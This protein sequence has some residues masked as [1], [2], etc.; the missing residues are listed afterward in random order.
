MGVP[1][2]L[3]STKL[4]ELILRL[5]GVTVFVEGNIIDLGVTQL[6]VVDACSGLRYILP[7]FALGVVFVNFY[8]KTRWKQIVVSISTLPIAI[9]VNALRIGIT[10]FLAQ[11]FGTEI[12]DGF[13]HGF[14]GWLIFILALLLVL[15]LFYILRGFSPKSH[16]ANTPNSSRESRPLQSKSGKNTFA[17]V[18]VSSILLLLFGIWS[19]TTAANPPLRIKGGLSYFPLTINGWHGRPENIDSRIISLSGAEDAFNGTY[20][21]AFGEIIS[22]YIGY[23]ASP[24][25]ESENFFH[26][27]NICLPSLGWN[28]LAISNHEITGVPKFNKLIVRKMLIEKMGYRQVVYYW[29]QTK[30]RVSPNVNINRLHLTLHALRRDNTHDLFIRPISPLKPEETVEKAQER[31]DHFV[32]VMMGSLLDFLAERQFVSY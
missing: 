29:F 13:F 4:G 9:I 6:Q 28:T 32:R 26:S 17:A 5:L 30:N 21:S 24:F 14:S 20:R 7:L 23:R 31:L 19:Y 2:Q 10:G 11:N 3:L 25:T 12:A 22:L 8:E 1:L 27:P 15:F 16:S 18:T